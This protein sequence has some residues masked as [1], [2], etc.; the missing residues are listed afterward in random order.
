[1]KQIQKKKLI[2]IFGCKVGQ[3]DPIVMKLLL[4][5][6]HC[7]PDVHA[8]FEIDIS[9]MYKRSLENFLLAGSPT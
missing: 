5:L 7:L 4:D 9:S 6:W 2:A 1:M 3:S 8:N